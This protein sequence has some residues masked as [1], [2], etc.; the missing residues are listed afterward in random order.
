MKWE[1]GQ[2]GERFKWGGGWESK[3]EEGEREGKRRGA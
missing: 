3:A 2:W 1:G